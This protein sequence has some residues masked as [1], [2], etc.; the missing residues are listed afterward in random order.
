MN[1]MQKYNGGNTQSGQHLGAIHFNGFA[2]SS[3]ACAAKI[4]CVQG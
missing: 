4:L 3:Y 2:S 1:F